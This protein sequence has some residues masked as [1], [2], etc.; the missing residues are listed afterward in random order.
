MTRLTGREA[1]FAAPAGPVIDDAEPVP[2]VA[3]L[4]AFETL[5]SALKPGPSQIFLA[6]ATEK[7]PWLR[8]DGGSRSIASVWLCAGDFQFAPNS[9]HVAAPQ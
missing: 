5:R 2:D 8:A 6:C 9:G 1:L 7:P 3:H 4:A